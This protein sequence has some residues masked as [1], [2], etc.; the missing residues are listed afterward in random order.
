MLL[1]GVLF[2]FILKIKDCALAVHRTVLA[3][4]H[5]TRFRQCCSLQKARIYGME[6]HLS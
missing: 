6:I 5:A 2:L 1:F 4:I 3:Q